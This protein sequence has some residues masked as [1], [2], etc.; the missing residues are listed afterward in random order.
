MTIKLFVVVVSHVSYSMLKT[1]RSS[2]LLISRIIK[3][4]DNEIVSG[5]AQWI[6]DPG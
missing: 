1:T 2:K 4:G 6:D 5:G 3:V